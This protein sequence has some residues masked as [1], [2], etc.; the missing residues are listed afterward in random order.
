MKAR[1]EAF[2]CE[3]ASKRKCE[4]RG[5]RRGVRARLSRLFVVACLMLVPIGMGTSSSASTATGRSSLGMATGT[6]RRAAQ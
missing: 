5:C 1:G 6:V 4:A 2:E 3:V